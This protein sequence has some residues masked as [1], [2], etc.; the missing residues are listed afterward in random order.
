MRLHRLDLTSSMSRDAYWA[1][2]IQNL[3]EPQKFCQMTRYFHRVC[4][5]F[6]A[7]G[8]WYCI[9]KRAEYAAADAYDPRDEEGEEL[10]IV[11]PQA[12]VTTV[13]RP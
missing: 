9:E 6:G 4:P 11:I 12:I 5:S 2:L 7:V 3:L 13:R 8:E 1:W 10:E